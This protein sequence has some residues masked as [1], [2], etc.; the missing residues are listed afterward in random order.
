MGKLKPHACSPF[1][2]TLGAPCREADAGRRNLPPT[3]TAGCTQAQHTTHLLPAIQL[4]QGRSGSGTLLMPVTWGQWVAAGEGLLFRLL[5]LG[6][7]SH[8]E[9]TGSR[10]R[11]NQLATAAAAVPS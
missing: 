2:S 8:G 5:L 1:A 11:K 3:A 6:S 4:E 9:V 10:C 7:R